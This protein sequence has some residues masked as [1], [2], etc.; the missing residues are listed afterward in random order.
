MTTTY[1]VKPLVWVE[2]I[3]A[4]DFCYEEAVT[5]YGT[6]AIFN[7]HE[8]FESDWDGRNPS[9]NPNHTTLEEAKAACE[10]DWHERIS[11]ALVPD[12]ELEEIKSW[13][14]ERAISDC[15]NCDGTGIFYG[16][17]HICGC[18]NHEG[19]FER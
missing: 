19:G 3:Q 2:V 4:D 16:N 8:Q 15:R 13:L 6:Y 9:F 10:K 14:A 12:T 5:M 7:K 18:V 17:V 1:T 11:V